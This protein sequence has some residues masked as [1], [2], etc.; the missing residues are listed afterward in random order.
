MPLIL[1]I[2]DGGMPVLER[3][4]EFGQPYIPFLRRHRRETAL[5]SI[6]HRIEFVLAEVV[7]RLGMYR[8]QL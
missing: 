2:E 8:I 5:E 3:R 7:V 1:V 6:Y 4:D